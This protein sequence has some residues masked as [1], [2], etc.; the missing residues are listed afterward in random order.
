MLEK[1][2][3][4]VDK[5]TKFIESCFDENNQQDGKSFDQRINERLNK[6]ED[7]VREIVINSMG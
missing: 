6:L 3:E 7:N 1:F 5:A 2:K 4:D